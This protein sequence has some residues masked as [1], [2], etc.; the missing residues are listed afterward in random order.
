MGDPNGLTWVA[1]ILAAGLILL[2]F[3]L[4]VARTTPVDLRFRRH[5][6]KPPARPVPDPVR[7]LVRAALPTMGAALL[8]GDMENRTRLQKRLIHA[9]LYGKQVM[10]AFLGVKVMLMLIPLFLG[11][12]VSLLGV[13][14]LQEG[15][16]YGTMGVVVGLIGPSFWLDRVK[17][18]RQVAFRRAFP[19]ALDVI[20]ICLEG[21]LSL[22]GA[23]R[24]VSPELRTAHPPLAREF[25]IVQREAHLGHS[26]G[27]ALRR[28]GDR[29][30]LEEVRS[31]GTLILQSER[32][33]TSL[34]KTLRVHAEVLR[35]RRVQYAEEM[36]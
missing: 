3:L 13:V 27:E 34:V 22:A 23:L 4:L 1:F 16:V 18:R 6:G 14:S 36:A 21:G 5:L 28:F 12:V 19:D 33:G 10:R 15:L 20:V 30:D 31:L 17:A 32:F 2:V 26:T 35:A 7:K 25:D 24:R 11:V 29:A 8:P 9:G